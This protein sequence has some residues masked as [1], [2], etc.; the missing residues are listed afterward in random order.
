MAQSQS[1]RLKM[2]YK[3]VQTIPIRA[4]AKGYP[5]TQRNSGMCVKF[6]P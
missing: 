1:R 5:S 4:M 6:I 2:T 3:L